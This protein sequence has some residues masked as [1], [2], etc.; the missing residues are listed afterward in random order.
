M[1]ETY[2]LVCLL[3]S[4]W[5]EVLPVVFTSQEF[6]KRIELRIDILV[7]SANRWS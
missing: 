5:G 7:S 6:R 4:K 1:L 2:Y 3:G